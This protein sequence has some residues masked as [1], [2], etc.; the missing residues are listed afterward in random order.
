MI[1][2]VIDIAEHTS[3]LELTS[4]V[5]FYDEP[6]LNNDMLPSDDTT[7]EKA[8]TLVNMPVQAKYRLSP[9]GEPTFSGHEMKKSKSTGE[10]TFG[11]SS[12]GT[13]TEVYIENDNVDV[14]GTIKNLPCLFAQRNVF[15]V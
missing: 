1:G 15:L 11:T 12:V 2:Q 14:N 7:L 13:H 10:I 6:N 8:Q 9:S 5:C 3:Y 4:R